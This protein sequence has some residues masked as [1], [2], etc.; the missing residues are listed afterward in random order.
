[1]CIHT[2]LPRTSQCCF[3]VPP[4]PRLNCHPAKNRNATE[5][6]SIQ[7][8]PAPQLVAA[9]WLDHGKPLNLFGIFFEQI[10]SSSYVCDEHALTC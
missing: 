3:M 1:M 5:Q 8:S 6:E 9:Q 4:F 7:L 10:G 2:R